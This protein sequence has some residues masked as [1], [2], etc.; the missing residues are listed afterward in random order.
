MNNIFILVMMSL[1][2]LAQEKKE[3]VSLFDGKTLQ[4]WNVPEGEDIKAVDGEI[5]IRIV[6]EG[7]MI[8]FKFEDNGIGLPNSF[9]INSSGSTGMIVVNSLIDQLEGELEILTNW[10]HPEQTK[11]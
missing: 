1:S 6:Q 3:P 5:Q 10:N 11:C 8:N 9:D 4:G 2:L 7:D